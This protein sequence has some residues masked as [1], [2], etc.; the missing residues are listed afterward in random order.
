MSS[1]PTRPEP[2][3]LRNTLDAL[4][5]GGGPAGLASALALG[6]VLRSAAFFD[7][8]QYRNETSDH[9][10][11]IP[12]HDGESPAS[13]RNRMR[14]EIETKY[15][16]ITFVD[17]KVETARKNDAVFEVVDDHGKVWKG[18]KL[19]L[20]TGSQDI[21]PDIPGFK[22]AWGKGILHCLFCRGFEEAQAGISQAAI[23]I[24]EEV[25]A[26]D[27]ENFLVFCQMMLQFS[28]QHLTVL[29][30]GNA[31]SPSHHKISALAVSRGFRIE[32]KIIKRLTYSGNGAKTTVN[33]ADGSDETFD[34]LFYSPPSKPHGDIAAQLGLETTTSGNI[35]IL[36]S[37]QE[38]SLYGVFGAGDCSTEVKKIAV[39]M[40]A[41]V[42]A[43]IGANSQIIKEDIEHSL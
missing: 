23:I 1:T 5:I 22:E 29:L 17:S 21:L 7:S 16:T 43:G 30:N 41:G 35:K 33:Y 26:Q 24:P 32:G 37:L 36:G 8:R 10:H 18:R 31:M 34:L 28:P 12:M 25:S 19:I 39:A 15:K 6:R 13:V 42:S 38:T 14:S 40:G 20:A 27:A 9:A 3:T 11:T 2:D 4:I